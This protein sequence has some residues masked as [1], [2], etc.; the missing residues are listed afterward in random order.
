M[1]A[2][3]NSSAA[4]RRT[5]RH[6]PSSALAIHGPPSNLAASTHLTNRDM[7][8]QAGGDDDE[9]Y[10]GSESRSRSPPKVLRF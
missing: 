2:P 10:G 6:P 5:M 3:E 4:G 9:I 7:L 8:K 1:P